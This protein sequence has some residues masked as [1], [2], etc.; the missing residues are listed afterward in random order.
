VLSATGR[1]SVVPLAGTAVGTALVLVAV[2]LL[3]TR[4]GA[5]PPDE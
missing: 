4:A 5:V 2:G 1:L 3:R